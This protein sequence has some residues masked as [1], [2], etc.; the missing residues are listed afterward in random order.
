MGK[1]SGNLN[2]L[3]PEF[4]KFLRERKLAPEKHVPFLAFWV[5]RFLT[6]C[7][8]RDISTEEYCEASVAEFLDM[9]RAD[10]KTPDWQPRQA[11]DAIRLYY[12][13][14]LGKPPVQHTAAANGDS[15]RAA[16][17]EVIRLMRLR[18]YSR[19]TEQ[20]YRQ[21]I[22]RFFDYAASGDKRPSELASPDFRDFMS[23][24]AMERNVA[25]STQNQ[26]FN[27][28]LFLYRYVL[29]KETGD[30]S[31]TVRA[32][33]GQKLPAVFTVEEVKRLLDNMDGT[34]RLIAELIYGAGL[35]LME[36]A[37]LRV[38]DIDF[39]ASTVYVRSGKG[40]KDRSTVLPSAVR[41]RLGAHLI[42]VKE[43][44]DADLKSGHGEVHMPDALARKYPK[45][46]K[47]WAWQY[48]FPSSRLSVD[49]RSGKVGEPQVG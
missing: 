43:L 45:A 29:G 31:N 44:H 47:E 38:K 49:P 25:A 9:L 26:A 7:S 8:R 5:S 24:L 12:V 20:T 30:L 15:V 14:F 35:R 46:A 2:E 18:H 1:L 16:V 28:V 3:L 41:E 17:D 27:A 10:E 34:Y 36:L 32:K 42:R 4:Q 39:D 37:R 33:R 48:V 40:D 21:W 22:E 6:F 13:H 23:H 19:S 11:D